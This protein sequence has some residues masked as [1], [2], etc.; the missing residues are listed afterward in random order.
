M[1]ESISSPQNEV[2]APKACRLR[3]RCHWIGGLIA[4]LILGSF[5]AV[6]L[7]V[8]CRP[9]YEATAAI[10]VH[11]VKPSF[12]VDY[13]P[14]SQHEYDTFVNTQ[15]VL[16]RQP[17]VI[18]RTLEAPEVSRLQMMIQ[19]GG[20]K[21]AWL[22][23]NLQVKRVRD[24]EIIHVSIKTN[25]EDASERIVNAVVNAYFNFTHELAR[26]TSNDLV[27]NLRTEERRQLH[28]IQALQETIH[29][30]TSE[31]DVSHDMIQL[32]QANKMLERINDRILAVTTEQRAPGRIIQLSRAVLSIKPTWTEQVAIAGI[33]F[34]LFFF[35]PLFCVACW[36]CCC[37]M[38]QIR[39]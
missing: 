38:M 27:S 12:L 31:E 35:L 8:V 17:Q 37:R 11:S 1:S 29:G 7:L 24:S 3:I 30:K 18:D 39:L 16:L 19:Q 21:R 10:Q 20:N 28:S 34:I 4:G 6:V 13:P 26:Q 22:T 14:M 23:R 15:I 32:E 36:R 25:S 33:G 2:D 5:V 9:Q